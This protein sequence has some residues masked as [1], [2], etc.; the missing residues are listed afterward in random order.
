MIKNS[1]FVKI[2]KNEN[3]SKPDDFRIYP[4]RLTFVLAI[5]LPNL[6]L[7]NLGKLRKYPGLNCDRHLQMQIFLVTFLHKKRIFSQK[8]L[9]SFLRLVFDKPRP[10]F[11][12]TRENIFVPNT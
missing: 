10:F 1:V 5:A 3:F 6:D 2:E 12:Q 9:L 4:S 8:R 7:Q 11:H